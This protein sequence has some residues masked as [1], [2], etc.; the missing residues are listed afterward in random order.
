MNLLEPVSLGPARA[1]SRV[2]FGPH[3]TNLGQH[4]AIS[5]R[6]VAYYERR[7]AGGCGVIVTEIASVHPS[8]WPY[9]RAPL[10]ADCGPGWSQTAAACAPHGAL[11][12]A[13]LGHAGMQGSSAFSQSALWAPSRVPDAASRELPMEM[14]E[15]EINAV[16]DGFAAAAALARRSGLAGVEINAGQY[17]LLRQFMSGLTNQRTDAHGQDRLLLTERVLRSVRTALGRDQVLGLR[18]CCDELAPWAGLTPELAAESAVRLAGLVDYLVVVRGSIYSVPATR[19]DLHSEPGFGLELC[20][21]IRA[22]VKRDGE[23]GGR[24]IPVVLQGSVVDPAQAQRALADGAA[25]LV[26]MTRAQITD[27]DLVARLWAGQPERIRPCL[28]CNQACMVRDNR[29]PVITCVIEPGSGHE[30]EAGDVRGHDQNPGPVLVVGGGPAGM[31]AARVLAERGHQVRLAE[32]G[33]ALGGMLTTAAAVHGRDRLGVA[34]DW[35]R[36]ELERLDVTVSLGHEVS[37]AELDDAAAQGMPVLLATGS[38][39]GPR[40]YRI[41]PDA[42]VVE[43]ADLASP[44]ALDQLPEGRAVVFDPIGGPVGVGVAELLAAHGR[45]TSIVT[46]DQIAGSQLALTGDLAEANSRLQRAGV[47]RE[48]RAVLREAARDHVLLEDRWTGE[49]RTVDCGFVVHCG[50][51]LPAE[52]LYQHRPGTWRAGDCVAPRTVL[53]AVH[54]ARRAAMAICAADRLS[55]RPALI[56]TGGG[57]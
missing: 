2:M 31:E 21:L 54:E 38:V 19:P 41:A 6:H 16:V 48:L 34:V 13:G 52:A 9:E 40:D 4:R 3:E 14:A 43:A 49:Q 47:R 18:L 44:G 8:D 55:G 30:H 35:W 15:T 57:R 53:E 56:M 27:P 17:S 42:H 22:A 20:R 33:P 51:R 50:H 32:R 36:R 46:Q 37:A 29:N 11:V 45:P 24:A 39:P 25:D 10:A 12:L 23:V 7:A 26:E 28:L 5:A 1:P